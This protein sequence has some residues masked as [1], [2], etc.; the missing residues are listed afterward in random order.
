MPPPKFLLS[1]FI[2]KYIN[3]Q[4]S[5]V[6]IKFCFKFY[7][8]DV[9]FYLTFG[10]QIYCKIKFH[11]KNMQDHT[12]DSI[13]LIKIFTKAA[14]FFIQCYLLYYQYHNESM[15]LSFLLEV[16]GMILALVGA[17]AFHESHRIFFIL[18]SL[19]NFCVFYVF[20]LTIKMK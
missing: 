11:I 8:I 16:S 2:P 19:H 12:F 17:A 14:L 1:L 4:E 10:R 18:V 5:W 6:S 9:K 3:K 15:S 13:N 20:F 7:S